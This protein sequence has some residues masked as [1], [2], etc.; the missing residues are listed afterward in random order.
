ME[1]NLI[2]PRPQNFLT[3]GIMIVAWGFIAVIAGQVVA[4]FSNSNQEG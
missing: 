3:I 4:K 1:V 2:T